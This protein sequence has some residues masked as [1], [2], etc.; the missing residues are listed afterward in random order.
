MKPIERLSQFFGKYI[1]DPWEP[2]TGSANFSF[3]HLKRY[4][5]YQISSVD[6][7]QVLILATCSAL[8]TATAKA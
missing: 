4:K 5:F 3:L 1:Q 8:Q 7:C 2:L 6:I